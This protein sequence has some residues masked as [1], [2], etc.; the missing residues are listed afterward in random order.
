MLQ[1]DLIEGQYLESNVILGV[2]HVGGG[3]PHGRE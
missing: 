1:W 3:Y 2:Y